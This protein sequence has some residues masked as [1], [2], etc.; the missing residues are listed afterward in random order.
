M[1]NN[2]EGYV[3]T[4]SG[5]IL[6]TDDGGTNWSML[7]EPG[8]TLNSIHFPPTLDIG[9]T[10]GNN[11]TI[12]AFTDSSF[13]DMTIVTSNL[14]SIFFPVN[15]SEG[16]LCGDSIIRRYLNGTW[17]NIQI[18]DSTFDYDSIFFIDN[19]TGWV[20]GSQGKIFKTVDAT[21]WNPQWNTLS[22]SLNDVFF[23]DSLEGWTVG[24]EVILHTI[25][26]GVTWTQEFASQTVGMEL[27]AVYF[28]S[29][30]NGY[31]VGTGNLLKYGEITPSEDV[32]ISL[33]VSLLQNYPNPFN[34]ETEISYQVSGVS[35]VS[36]SIFDIK[37]R[38]I[39]TL[40]DDTKQSGTHSVIW[41]GKDDNDDP[42]C[43]GIYFS[44]L[45]AG[46]TILTK[47]MVLLK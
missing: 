47:R 25:D 6:K 16:K 36:L 31:V 12:Y 34:P 11:G 24:T 22:N 10:C 20:V 29:A 33:D 21:I 4:Y 26:G 1:K 39:K 7:H 23:I 35:N 2:H 37:G 30:N 40:I 9:Y 32:E 28:T 45:V 8:G 44:R 3:V 14:R 27:T 42:V 18:F 38:L 5:N 19:N 43:S 17:N 13:V 46:N 41:T 15:S